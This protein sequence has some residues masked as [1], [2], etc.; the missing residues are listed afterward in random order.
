MSQIRPA[1]WRVWQRERAPAHGDGGSQGRAPL[2]LCR[3][4]SVAWAC[5]LGYWCPEV[6]PGWAAQPRAL[7]TSFLPL[8]PLEEDRTPS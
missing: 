5:G 4:V 2:W 1:S 7:S 3:D 6:C 8:G